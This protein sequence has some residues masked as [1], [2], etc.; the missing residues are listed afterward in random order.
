MHPN[1][2]D[3]AKV[4]R[5]YVPFQDVPLSFLPI[6]CKP[7]ITIRLLTVSDTVVSEESSL[8]E[9]QWTA[10]TMHLPDCLV[11]FLVLCAACAMTVSCGQRAMFQASQAWGML[12]SVLT[13]RLHAEHA[14]V[15]QPSHLPDVLKALHALS[16]LTHGSTYS[17]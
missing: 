13:C 12:R 17:A 11:L 15:E 6:N 8:S 10:M 5:F 1:F 3:L 4:T 16:M 14:D 9:V 2:R 7:C